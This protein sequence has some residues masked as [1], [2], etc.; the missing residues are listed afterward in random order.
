MIAFYDLIKLD[1][2]RSVDIYLSFALSLWF[3]A[4][5]CFIPFFSRLH[6]SV[7]FIGHIYELYETQDTLTETIPN[8]PTCQQISCAKRNIK[9][10]PNVFMQPTSQVNN[11]LTPFIYI[12]CGSNE[13]LSSLLCFLVYELGLGQRHKKHMVAR[14]KYIKRSLIISCL[15]EKP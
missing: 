7:A 2:N 9:S 12:L 15:I 5:L 10:L 13:V 6:V 14:K 4:L 3:R 11:Y 1:T 8:F